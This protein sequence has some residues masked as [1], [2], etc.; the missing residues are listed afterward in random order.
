[1]PRNPI[2]EKAKSYPYT[3]LNAGDYVFSNK[4]SPVK[5]T[6]IEGR[7]ATLDCGATTDLRSTVFAFKPITD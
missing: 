6:K 3:E 7:N 1:M 4:G 2:M 5:I